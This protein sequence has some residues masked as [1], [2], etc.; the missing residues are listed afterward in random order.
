MREGASCTM[1]I[2]GHKKQSGVHT[3]IGNPHVLDELGH[4]GVVASLVVRRQKIIA[5]GVPQNELLLSRGHEG[6]NSGFVMIG[7][8]SQESVS[9]DRVVTIKVKRRLLFSCQP[10]G[11]VIMS[12]PR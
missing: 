2:S 11:V 12:A 6:C 9:N 1:C 10:A 8:A 5:A 7:P 3:W 4:R